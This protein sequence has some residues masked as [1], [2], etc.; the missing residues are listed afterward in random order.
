MSRTAGGLS[1]TPHPPRAP[2]I[3]LYMMHPLR[4][5]WLTACC[6]FFDFCV[7]FPVKSANFDFLMTKRLCFF[8]LYVSIAKNTC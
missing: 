5:K 8:R 2:Y 4:V 3:I 1:V 6:A 7:Y